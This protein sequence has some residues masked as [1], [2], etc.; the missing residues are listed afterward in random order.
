MSLQTKLTKLG[1]FQSRKRDTVSTPTRNPAAAGVSFGTPQPGAASDGS[2]PPSILR[3]T[4]P[5][6]AAT[7]NPASSPEHKKSKKS[8]TTKT[9]TNP[10]SASTPAAAA[11]AKAAAAPKKLAPLLYR[12]FVKGSVSVSRCER[13]RPEVYRKLG[14]MLTMFQTV[15]GGTGTRILRHKTP[16]ESP[17][18]SALYFP[19]E[20]VVMSQ[21][22]A[23]PGEAKQWIGRTIKEGK[24]RKLEFTMLVASNVPIKELVDAVQIDLIDHEVQIEYKDCQSIASENRLTFL[25]MSN[26]FSEESMSLFI[27][28]RFH[29]I[30]KREYNRDATSF[31]GQ[32]HAKSV[33]FPSIVI[34]R[35]FPYNGIWE[36]R[37]DGEYRDNSYKQAFVLEC[38]TD[39]IEQVEFAAKI[40]KRSGQL[41]ADFG[42]HATMVRAPEKGKGTDETVREKYHQML[43]S[44]QAVQLSTGIIALP[45]VTNPDY[46]VDVEYW[47][48]TTR[49][50]PAAKIERTCLR[51]LLHGITVNGSDRPVQVI[52][53]L[54]RKSSGHGFE[55]GVASVVPAAKSLATNISEHT[56]GWVKGYLKQLNWKG[57]CINKL[58][59]GSFT[60]E[61]VMA[62][63]QSTWD[64]KTGVVTSDFIS[65]DDMH[66]REMQSSWVDMHLGSNSE[67]IDAVLNAGDI[68]AFNFED[69]VSVASL[70]T[71]NSGLPEG[72]DDTTIA[73]E[74]EVEDL[75]G[76]D[77]LEDEVAALE[78]ELEEELEESL[79]QWMRSDG[80]DAEY[81]SDISDESSDDDEMEESY[82][83]EDL[84]LLSFEDAQDDLAQHLPEGWHEQGEEEANDENSEE[85]AMDSEEEEELRPMREL[86]PDT[87]EFKARLLDLVDQGQVPRQAW[88][89]V[90]TYQALLREEAEIIAAKTALL[91]EDEADADVA[92]KTVELENL[93]AKNAQ[94]IADMED[95]IHTVLQSPVQQADEANGIASPLVEPQRGTESTAEGDSPADNL[96]IALAGANPSAGDHGGRGG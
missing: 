16:E 4:R 68:M 41:K 63:Q 45:D 95:S 6:K 32:C 49:N 61:S 24:T 20:H 62:A 10:K 88:D 86:F 55:A 1:V 58:L 69:G 26:K 53:G 57:E 76:N 38:S 83:S 75:T 12:G 17:L 48:P 54:C 9:S 11:P 46:M 90:E 52:Q 33:V 67:N 80:P 15:P 43:S 56:A 27:E 59:R 3:R 91:N 34:R 40:Y 92:T 93:L 47:R 89:L 37:K 85:M 28:K 30:Q 22:F 39:D 35:E 23:F 14:V 25:C 36:E 72:F 13:L 51:E 81:K 74:A 64:K 73:T 50:T 79:P 70:H 94:S 82:A 87:P 71:T 66:L 2:M 19:T 65:A 7:K 84:N 42:E 21:Y 18:C 77:E 60:A 78:A 8:P 96:R 44:H 5:D 31:L 29:E